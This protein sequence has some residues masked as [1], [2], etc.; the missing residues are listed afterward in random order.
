MHFRNALKIALGIVF[1]FGGPIFAYLVFSTLDRSVS[2]PPQHVSK[3]TKP[4]TLFEQSNYWSRDITDAPVDS[5][6]KRYIRS[7][8]YAVFNQG[9]FLAHKKFTTPVYIANANPKRTE[10]ILTEN[11]PPLRDLRIKN[12]PIISY[13]KPDPGRIGLTALETIISFSQFER[14]KTGPATMAIIDESTNS[15]FEFS[16][17]NYN[18]DDYNAAWGGVL[19]LDGSG[20]PSCGKAGIAGGASITAG[21]IWPEEILNAHI[22]HTL[23]FSYPYLDGDQIIPPFTSTNGTYTEH[24]LQSEYNENTGGFTPIAPLPT[25]AIVRL[26]KN[27]DLDGFE[28]FDETSFKK[29]KL[30]RYEKT[31]LKAMQ[32]YGMTVIA[33]SHGPVLIHMVNAQSY[34]PSHYPDLLPNKD[35][36]AFPKELISKL[37]VIQI[38]E[39]EPYIFTS[40]PKENITKYWCNTHKTCPDSLA[41]VQ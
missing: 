27:F 12:I 34:R 13:A 30:H 11:A 4:P 19:E 40:I 31:I 8:Q 25:G 2:Y 24:R 35:L 21:L 6:S 41:C 38:P 5:L 32:Q 3:L 26:Q 15:V 10:I 14:V 7:L 22:P 9:F 23:F 1:I 37:D 39:T 29:R 33:K 36:I 28:F 18:P 16:R 17:L 20:L